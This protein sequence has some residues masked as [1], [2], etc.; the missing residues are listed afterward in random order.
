MLRPAR[1]GEQ[2]LPRSILPSTPGATWV[3]GRLA[4][5]VKRGP[6]FVAEGHENVDRAP[7]SRSE[8]LL[9][10]GC[11]DRRGTCRFVVEVSGVSDLN[12]WEQS[13]LKRRRPF[14]MPTRFGSKRSGVATV[15]VGAENPIP[16]VQAASRYSWISPA[17]TSVRRMQA[18]SGLVIGTL[19]SLTSEGHRL[20]RD[21]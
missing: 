3:K 4:S 14:D 5:R 1:G 18:G 15:P 13:L 11:F 7:R 8:G 17:R 12:E 19:A 10:L 9:Q 2:R 21:R 20:S 16:P 6:S